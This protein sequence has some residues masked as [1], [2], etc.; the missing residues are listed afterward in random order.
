[1]LHDSVILTISRERDIKQTNKEIKKTINNLS[2]LT[3]S[4]QHATKAVHQQDGNAHENQNQHNNNK[5][6]E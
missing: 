2:K 1:M 6:E 4:Q 3:M 5:V